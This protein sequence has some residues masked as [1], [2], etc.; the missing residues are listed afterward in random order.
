VKISNGTI[1]IPKM[2]I[3]SN[4]MNI[5]LSGSHTFENEID[6][7]FNFKLSEILLRREESEFG[8]IEDD[9]T[10]AKIFIHMYGTTDN[11]QFEMDRKGAKESRKEDF[12]AE[13]EKFKKIINEELF[14]KGVGN[15]DL[16]NEK[17]QKAIVTIIEEDPEPKVI[18]QKEVGDLK[19]PVIT[20]PRDIIVED[21]KEDD[22]DD[23]F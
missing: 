12:I 8:K 16:K 9:G 18:A 11:P 1:S 2:S 10:G 15:Q 14:K 7:Q 3:A 21:E 22:D 17:E 5:N 20:R 6:Y 23:D 19:K 13:K 4:A